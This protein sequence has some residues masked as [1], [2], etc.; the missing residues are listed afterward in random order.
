MMW[1][2]EVY[3]VYHIGKMRI[4]IYYMYMR[5]H[6]CMRATAVKCGFRIYV[7][8]SPIGFDVYAASTIHT[9]ETA[10]KLSAIYK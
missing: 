1:I 2:Y 5:V 4:H 10:G 6:V 3:S 8:E 7:G 9:K